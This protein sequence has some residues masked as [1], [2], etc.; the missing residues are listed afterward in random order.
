MLTENLVSPVEQR[1]VD[2]LEAVHGPH[3]A[4]N[5][6]PGN[7]VVQVGQVRRRV[8]DRKHMR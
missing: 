1:T 2:S 8:L 3:G 4:C 5:V 7:E 6:E